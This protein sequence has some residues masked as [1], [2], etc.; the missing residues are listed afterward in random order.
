VGVQTTGVTVTAP[1][2]R[3]RDGLPAAIVGWAIARCCVAL[4]NLLAR[5]MGRVLDTPRGN[6]HLQEGLLTWDGTYYEVLAA[7]WYGGAPHDAARFFPLFPAFG[8][9]LTPMLGGHE[10][11][12]LVVIANVTALLGA[13]VLWRL[14]A[15]ALGDGRAAQRAAWMVAIFPGAFVLTFAY[16]EGPA[17][18]VVSATL[19]A[20][21]RRAFAVAGLLGLLGALLRPVGGLVLIPILVELYRARPRPTP[22]AAAVSVAG[23]VAGLFA[24][25]GWIASSTG[26]FWRPVSIQREIRGGFQDPITRLFEPIG[27]VATG[28]F[29]DVYNLAV[30]WLLVALL[31]V[32]FRRRQ[33]ASWLAFA[34][35]SLLVLLSSQVTD[36]IGRYAMVVVP[37]VT[38]LAQ[39]AERRWQQAAVAV[40]GCAGLIWMSSEAWLGRLVP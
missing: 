31:Y 16:S 25:L 19:L 36:S 29:R 27:E 26:D 11:W 13:L 37:F 20:L 7:Q 34:S 24:A 9:G 30:M 33:P 28:N 39:W 23:P 18:L 1:P 21:H 14:V 8:R 2:L 10:G 6:H 35:V 12:A 5:P 3:W 38:A 4:G 22:L 32:A 15:E 17:L 40:C